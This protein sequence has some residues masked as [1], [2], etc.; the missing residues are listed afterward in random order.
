M[1]EDLTI[2]SVSDVLAARGKT[3]K[4]KIET[5]VQKMA[6]KQQKTEGKNLLKLI[7]GSKI[8]VMA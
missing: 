4:A 3:Q 7:K 6:I 2:N 1:S 8:D 5:G